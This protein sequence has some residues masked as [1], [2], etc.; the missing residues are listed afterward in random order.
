M[1]KSEESVEITPTTDGDK[2]ILSSQGT[3]VEFY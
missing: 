1:L 3:G 2:F